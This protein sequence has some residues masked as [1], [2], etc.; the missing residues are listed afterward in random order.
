MSTCNVVKSRKGVRGSHASEIWFT[1]EEYEKAKA[2][3]LLRKITK[4]LHGFV[5]GFELRYH[6]GHYKIGRCN[7]WE[8][9]KTHYTGHNSP[10][11]MLFMK[12]VKDQFA[13]EKKHLNIARKHLI[14]EEFGEEWF[15]TEMSFENV[16]LLFC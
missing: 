12:P 5:Y 10:G 4:Q 9:R 15:K 6:P 2:N 16:C 1:A 8:N 3:V 13:A 14:Q 7:I 11:K